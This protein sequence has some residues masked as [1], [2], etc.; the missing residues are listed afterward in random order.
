M[1]CLSE[2]CIMTSLSEILYYIACLCFTM[3][4]LRG[5]MCSNNVHNIVFLLV[6]LD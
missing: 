5:T 4:C 6:G 2:E 3:T 1:T